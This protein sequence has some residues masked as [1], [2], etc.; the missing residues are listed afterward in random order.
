MADKSFKTLRDSLRTTVAAAWNVEGAR[1]FKAKLEGVF[2][3]SLRDEYRDCI[4][5]STTIPED[6]LREVADKA[7][8]RKEYEEAWT[9]APDKLIEKLETVRGMWT[10]SLRDE[11]AEVVESLDIPKLYQMCMEG[12]FAGVVE[13]ANL[14]TSPSSFRECAREVAKARGLREKLRG[15]WGKKG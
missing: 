14:A 4:D 15:K 10:A 8:L 11:I 3:D 6:C 9:G 7:G 12:D 2:P 5:S 1:D 13:K